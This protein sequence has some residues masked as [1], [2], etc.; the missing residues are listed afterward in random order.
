[1]SNPT[2]EESVKV[3]VPT[4]SASV[5]SG[6]LHGGAQNV[7]G[8]VG[9]NHATLLNRSDVSGWM[10]KAVSSNTALVE[11]ELEDQ[12]LC[13]FDGIEPTATSR[14]AGRRAESAASAAW[15]TRSTRKSK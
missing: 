11:A 15:A 1:V 7:G 8:K 4:R 9:R 14:V 10:I 2:L 6:A 5:Y 13:V 3:S 12:Q